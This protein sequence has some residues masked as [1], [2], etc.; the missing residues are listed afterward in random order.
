MDNPLVPVT[1]LGVIASGLILIAAAVA[2]LKWV[3]VPGGADQYARGR[4]FQS[5]SARREPSIRA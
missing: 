3:P 1:R 2:A 5:W 4:S